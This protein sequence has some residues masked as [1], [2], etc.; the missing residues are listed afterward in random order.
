MAHVVTN[1]DRSFLLNQQGHLIVARLTPEGY[2]EAGRMLLVE[3][4]AGYRPAGAVCWAHPAFANKQVFARND[5]E[6]VCV[7]L[8]AEA[9][10]ADLTAETSR[11]KSTLLPGTWD[12]DANQTHSVT[13]SPDGKLIALGTGWGLVRQVDLTTGALS[14]GAKRHNDWVCAVTYSPDGKYLVSAGGSEFTP[15]RNGGKTSAEIKVWNRAAGAERGKLEGH[16]NKIFSALFSPDGRTLATGAADQT[17]RLWDVDAMRERSVLRGHSDAISSLAWSGDGRTLASASWD[18]TVKLWD[19]DSGKEL[20]TLSGSDEEILGVA[21]SP[22]GR[23]VA[24]G[25][26]DWNVRLWDLNSTKLAAVVS[27]HRG[28]IYAVGFSPDGKILATGSGDETI[29]LWNLESRRSTETLRGHKSGVT[30]LAFTP[31]NRQLVSG[32]LDGPVRIWNLAP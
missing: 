30:S 32:A 6:L 11:L 8:S 15:E 9:A 7:S 17:V 31:D 27:G 3:P 29:R 4:T 24:A 25:G 2:R 13:V 23:W 5:H 19:I 1:G 10:K 26:S 28:T 20:A 12:A 22:D 14:P 21:I 16:T 18:K